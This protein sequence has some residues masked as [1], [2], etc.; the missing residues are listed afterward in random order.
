M[1]GLAW[2]RDLREMANAI[3]YP[4]RGMPVN[5]L[6]GGGAAEASYA[7]IRASRHAKGGNRNG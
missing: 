3:P 6:D 1:D 5:G 2:E 4:L 7:R